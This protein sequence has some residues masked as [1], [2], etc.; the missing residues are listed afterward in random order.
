MTF[1][2]NQ[3]DLA[4][5]MH[6]LLKRGHIGHG[7]GPWDVE[8]HHGGQFL[9][10]PTKSAF[11]IFGVLKSSFFCEKATEMANEMLG[12]TPHINNRPPGIHIPALISFLDS[13][14]IISSLNF[15]R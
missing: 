9:F 11:S 7:R 1:R 8:K 4:L 12:T 2:L 13:H 6:S 14:Y 5:I 10:R 15:D 3:L